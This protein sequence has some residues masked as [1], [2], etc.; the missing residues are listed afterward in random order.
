MIETHEFEKFD[1]LMAE[2]LVLHT[3]QRVIDD[4]V[5]SRDAKMVGFDRHFHLSRNPI[6]V[7]EDGFEEAMET[8][9][10]CRLELSEIERRSAERRS[11]SG[12]PG[13]PACGS[14]CFLKVPSSS[15]ENG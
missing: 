15:L 14:L 3:F 10:K 11:S 12:A 1:P 6:I 7:D 8:F 5:A 4:F 2:D 13:V 9:E